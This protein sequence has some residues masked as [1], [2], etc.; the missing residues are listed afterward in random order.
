MIV[1][2]PTPLSVNDVTLYAVP[3]TA[4]VPVPLKSTCARIP[5]F[6]HVG[7]AL[8]TETRPNP[9]VAVPTAVNALVPLPMRRPPA[10]N[11][12]APVPP[13][14]TGKPV[15]LVRTPDVGVPS[16]GVTNVGDVAKTQEPVPVSSVIAAIILADVGVA[17]KVAIPA[18]NPDTPVEIGRPVQLVNVPE[19]GVPSNGVTRVGDVANTQEPVPVSSV[20]A[21]IMFADVGVVKKVA[22]P[23]ARPE[24]PVEIGNPVQLVSVPDV[25]VPSRGVTNV[26]DVAKTHAPVPV[27]SVIAA[28]R[29]AEEGVARKVATPAARPEIPVETGRPVHDVN[30]PEDGVPSAPLKVTKAPA[31][32]TFTASAVATPVPRPEMPLEMGNPVQLVNVPEVGMPSNGVTKVGD[33]AKTQAPVP[34]SSVIAAMR[35]A[36]DGVAKKVATPAAKPDTPVEIGKPVHDVRVPEDGVPSAPLNVTKA[37]AEPTLIA[38]AVATP[39]PRPEMPVEIGKPVQDVSVPDEGVPSAPF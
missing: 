17:K 18:A 36:E 22:I 30:V 25:G 14:A 8:A 21:A 15:Q 12:A 26:G 11:V 1:Q 38:R 7:A 5:L 6:C 31:E 35:L 32:P 20:I 9:A 27:S 34:V 23:A 10:V 24:T 37:P 16:K 19:V 33:V 4:I 13:P 2:S 29:L 3:R 39:V 28:M